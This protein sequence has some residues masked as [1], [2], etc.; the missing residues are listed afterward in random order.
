MWDM[1]LTRRYHN[2]LSLSLVS[3]TIRTSCHLLQLILN[4]VATQ[5][6][7]MVSEYLT[8]DVVIL[9]LDDARRLACELLV[10]L[11]EVLVEVAHA[12]RYG[13]AHILVKTRKREATLLE[14][15]GLLRHLVDLSVD[16]YALEV[17]KRR[18]VLTP[19]CAVYDEE[20]D[21]LANLRCCK[22]HA[23]GLTEGDPHIL[24]K[25]LELGILGSDILRLITQNLR[26][27]YYDWINHSSFSF[28]VLHSDRCHIVLQDDCR[29][30]LIYEA[31]IAARHLAYATLAY[32]ALGDNRGEALIVWHNL[33]IGVGMA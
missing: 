2:K 6:C 31:L 32:C 20:A 8:L 11:Y 1:P 24:D 14:E 7:K 10:M 9:M 15:R 4:K 17:G 22:T 33:L 16:E 13:A 28:N 5:G 3:S 25:L 12:D 19:G 29:R 18:I 27:V 26:A 23:L 21:I 30:N